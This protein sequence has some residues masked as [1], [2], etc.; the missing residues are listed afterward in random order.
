[1]LIDT[2]IWRPP[3]VLQQSNPTMASKKATSKATTSLDDA[4]KATLVGEV[5]Q[6]AP[7]ND[8]AI[9]NSALA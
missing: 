6:K 1:V 8:G 7:K 2:N 4:V 5:P 9:N 3:F